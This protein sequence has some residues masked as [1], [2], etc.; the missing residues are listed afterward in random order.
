MRLR[1]RAHQIHEFILAVRPLYGRGRYCLHVV[2]PNVLSSINLSTATG[3]DNLTKFIVTSRA[4]AK[5][6]PEPVDN[7]Y[8]TEPAPTCPV[9]DF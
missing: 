7:P 6:L 9:Y 3:L 5:S 8:S 2:L 1:R 4:F